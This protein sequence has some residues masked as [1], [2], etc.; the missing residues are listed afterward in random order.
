MD[1][2]YNGN[3][4]I[5]CGNS[6]T[7]KLWEISGTSFI[8]R[9]QTSSTGQNVLT[10]KFAKYVSSIA[11]GCNNGD[12]YTYK[13]TINNLFNQQRITSAVSGSSRK[14]LDWNQLRNTTFFGGTD[15][16]LDII[17]SNANL[18]DRYG[19]AK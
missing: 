14:A 11:Y 10:C 17:D 3:N 12:A 4:F 7:V 13:Y 16:N 6:N 9:D 19:I 15:K 1:F 18:Q 2:N 5:T 8:Y